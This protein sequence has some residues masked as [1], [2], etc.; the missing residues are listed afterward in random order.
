MLHPPP[1]RQDVVGQAFREGEDDG[2]LQRIGLQ[3]VLDPIAPPFDAA[4]VGLQNK[5][6]TR[7]RDVIV[8][9]EL[10]GVILENTGK[11]GDYGET[12]RETRNTEWQHYKVSQTSLLQPSANVY[13]LT[14]IQQC[15]V[16]LII[17]F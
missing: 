3:H 7:I 9:T 2:I 14:M 5:W 13:L 4:Q 15:D 12:T 8:R 1:H 17:T 6:Y 16:T 10:P 11:K